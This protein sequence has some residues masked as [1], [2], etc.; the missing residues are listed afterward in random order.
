MI[1][2]AFGRGKGLT[3]AAVTQELRGELTVV[4]QVDDLRDEVADTLDI[5]LQ[6]QHD[7]VK[8]YVAHRTIATLIPRRVRG[9][10]GSLWP[11]AR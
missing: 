9:S 4:D 8:L 2:S 7:R 5:L 6:R 3:P 1:P 11:V 10:H